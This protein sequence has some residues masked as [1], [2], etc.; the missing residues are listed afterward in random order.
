MVTNAN[1]TAAE[2]KK[3]RKRASPEHRTEEPKAPPGTIAYFLAKARIDAKITKTQ[4][5]EKLRVQ[6]PV[7]SKVESG[8]HEGSEGMI[9]KYAVALNCE[10]VLVF[11]PLKK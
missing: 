4:M 6:L 9:I 8:R 5:A 11:K 3:S 1:P 7:I 10:F 2:G